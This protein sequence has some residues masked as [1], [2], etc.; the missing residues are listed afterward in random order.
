MSLKITLE[1]EVT[2]LEGPPTQEQDIAEA[3][4]HVFQTYEFQ[5]FDGVETFT[6]YDIT[7]VRPVK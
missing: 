4:V 3:L 7:K 2:R 5:V 6:A 1:V